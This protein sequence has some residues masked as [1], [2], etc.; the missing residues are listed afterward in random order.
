MFYKNKLEK[1][2]IIA[3]EEVLIAHEIIEQIEW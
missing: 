1:S 2:V 3:E